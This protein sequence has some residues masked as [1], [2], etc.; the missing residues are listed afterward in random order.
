MVVQQDNVPLRERTIQVSILARP[1]GRDFFTINI[2]ERQAPFD[3][4][5]TILPA[6]WLRTPALQPTCFV[7]APLPG[8]CRS[9]C[10]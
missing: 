5:S 9:R 4:K 3:L 7:P 2:E 8:V 1:R 6:T 10:P